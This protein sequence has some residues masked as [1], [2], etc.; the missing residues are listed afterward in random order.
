MVLPEQAETMVAALREKGIPVAY[1]AFGGEGHGFRERATI[2]RAL[3]AELAFYGRMLGFRPADPA[4]EL[5][6]H[7]LD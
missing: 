3:A 4:P 6:I 5:T 1:L 2:E 7:N